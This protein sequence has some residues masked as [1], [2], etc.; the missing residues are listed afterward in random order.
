MAGAP[1][2]V[3]VSGPNLDL[4]GERQP[5]VYGRRRLEEVV[6]EA[7][8]EAKRAGLELEHR[9]SNHEGDLVEAVH[10]ARGRAQALIV[11]AGALS[12]YS[13]SLH[14]ALASFEGVVVEVHLSNPAAR[15]PWRHDSVLA[16]VADGSIA[17]FGPLGYRLAVQA[18][19]RLLTERGEL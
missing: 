5:E 12:H 15:E 17:G 2:V 19:A 1:L 10:Q 6:A 11:N 16:P 18:V 4:L 13:W 8:E 7:S 9:Q 3:L 14:D